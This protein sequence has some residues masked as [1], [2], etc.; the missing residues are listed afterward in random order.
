MFEKYLDCESLLAEN[1][2]LT[3]D[4]FEKWAKREIGLEN[5]SQ[6]ILRIL[7]LYD[8]DLGYNQV[9]ELLSDQNSFPGIELIHFGDSI[10][11]I[12][13]RATFDHES[14]LKELD[15]TVN[16]FLDYY[17][18]EEISGMTRK[19]VF[20]IP[21]E[22]FR[23]TV[24]NALMH[25]TWDIPAQIRVMMFDDRIEVTSPG[26]LPAGLSEEEYS[27]G[28]IS[29]LRNPILGNIFY[30]LH[31]VETLGTG[32]LRIREAYKDSERKPIFEA[33]ANSVKVTLPVQG[34]VEM[35]SVEGL[36]YDTLSKNILKPIGEI[37][38]ALPYSRSKV[39]RI[40]KDLIAKNLVVK[41]GNGR[42]TRYKKRT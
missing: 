23:E 42:G 28:N 2:D 14:V 4:Y 5:F 31:I 6:D 11:V 8:D 12:T 25:R 20:R 33:F 27:R 39:S 26:V 36:A 30:R 16:V 1:Q 32:I 38:D 34:Q 37:T 17:S 41:V 40:L 18:Y 24:A 9:A 35:T 29:I 21:E 15:D 13:K 10:N 3:F 7:N 22:A 19:K